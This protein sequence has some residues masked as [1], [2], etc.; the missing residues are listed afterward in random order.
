MK[1][2]IDRIQSFYQKQ[3]KLCYIQSFNLVRC[4][5]EIGILTDNLMVTLSALPLVPE[6]EK[7]IVTFED[8]KDLRIGSFQGAFR[9]D[10]RIQ[11]LSADQI[12]NI[13]FQVKE[14]EYDAFSFVCRCFDWVRTY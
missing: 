6:G 9:L 3:Y 11:D 7:L 2:T 12:E 5:N 13:N 10:I 1:N 8:V 14:A 4:E